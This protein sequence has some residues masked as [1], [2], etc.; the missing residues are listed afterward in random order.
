[1]YQVGDIAFY[2]VYGICKIEGIEER[3]FHGQTQL[4]YILHST[5]YPSMK[6][7]HPVTSEKSNLKKI[8][9]EEA[10]R[11]LLDCFKQPGGEWNEH[12]N[13]RMQQFKEILNSNGHVKIAE[14]M[15]TLYR[16]KIELEGQD[17]KLSPQYSQIL[18]KLMPI[19]YEE[20]SIALELP[21]ETIENKIDTLVR[22][23]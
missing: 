21:K 5:H 7:Y 18:Q 19:L 4:Y 1:M 8:L 13:T 23:H 10:A 3:E 20:L 15:N 12:S 6:L 2:N 16:K 9:T 11:S 22:T 17:K 14:L